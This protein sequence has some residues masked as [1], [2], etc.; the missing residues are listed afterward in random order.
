MNYIPRRNNTEMNAEDLNSLVQRT[1]EENL[2]PVYLPGFL[3]S[4]ASRIPKIPATRD[5]RDSLLAMG[6]FLDS[7][8]GMTYAGLMYRFIAD[9][10]IR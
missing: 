8:I 5:A 2:W 7:A 4:S 9:F 6:F 10:L 1:I 3:L